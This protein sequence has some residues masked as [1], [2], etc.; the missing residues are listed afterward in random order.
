MRD[1][2]IATSKP[3]IDQPSHVT[4]SGRYPLRYLISEDTVVGAPFT[5]KTAAPDRSP[6]PQ[7]A[8]SQGTTFLRQSEILRIS[9][10]ANTANTDRWAL[11]NKMTRRKA[12]SGSDRIH[13]RRVERKAVKSLTL[14]ESIRAQVFLFVFLFVFVRKSTSFESSKFSSSSSFLFVSVFRLSFFSSSP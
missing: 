3:L 1:T 8:R 7:P 2:G 5:R 13:Q 4:E 6:G 12:N 10:T 14:I 9:Y 11:L